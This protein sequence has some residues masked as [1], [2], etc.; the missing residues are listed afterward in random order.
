MTPEA[1][2]L[3]RGRLGLR[4]EHSRVPALMA[5]CLRHGDLDFV[6]GSTIAGKH[7]RVIFELTKA[8]FSGDD[9][10]Q[11]YGVFELW[12][13]WTPEVG[14]RRFLEGCVQWAAEQLQRERGPRP[15]DVDTML[16]KA[17]KL[18]LQEHGGRYQGEPTAVLQELTVR[19]LRI[20]E[21]PNGWPSNAE[22]LGWLIRKRGKVLTSSGI[23]VTRGQTPGK[24]RRRFVCFKA[25]P[26]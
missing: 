20:S 14:W 18:L 15:D 24:V 19:A 8:G 26:A 6:Q 25:L 10:K 4:L 13:G 11:I 17:V 7:Q 5:D 21:L 1:I 16:I 9:V 23:A 22:R 3:A 12:K 2:E